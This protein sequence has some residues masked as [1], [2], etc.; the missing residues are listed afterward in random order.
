MR[1]SEGFI[2]NENGES[3]Q[4]DDVAGVGRG[5]LELEKLVTRLME[6]NR[7]LAPETR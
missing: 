1:N 7:E 3:A 2:D 5:E 4:E 6:R